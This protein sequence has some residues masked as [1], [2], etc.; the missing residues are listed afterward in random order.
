MG[1]EIFL[2]KFINLID[3]P[4]RNDDPQNIFAE[5]LLKNICI[6]CKIRT[7]CTMMNEVI[8]LLLDID[9]P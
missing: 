6:V 2:N 8:H 4:L 5:N 1:I 3:F 9:I 7:K